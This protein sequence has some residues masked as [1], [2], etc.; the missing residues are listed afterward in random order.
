MV[1]AAS[2]VSLGV[3]LG[4]AARI[5]DAGT[6][7]AIIVPPVFRRGTGNFTGLGAEGKERWERAR[8]V[9]V[10]EGGW[11]NVACTVRACVFVLAWV[12]DDAFEAGVCGVRCGQEML[13]WDSS[14]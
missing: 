10:G 8:S 9:G 13:R 1:V 3:G 4:F 14:S 6:R 11:R 2:T 12:D 5:S 7:T